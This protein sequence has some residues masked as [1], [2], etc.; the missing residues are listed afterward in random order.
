VCETIPFLILIIPDANDEQAAEAHQSIVFLRRISSALIVIGQVGFSNDVIPTNWY[1]L[2]KQQ[3][4]LGLFEDS[5]KASLFSLFPINQPRA[6][7]TSKMAFFRIF[8]AE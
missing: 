1:I 7:S 6:K 5:F 4:S 2:T 8:C 3:Y